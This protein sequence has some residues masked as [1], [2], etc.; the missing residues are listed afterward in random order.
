MK[1]CFSKFLRVLAVEVDFKSLYSVLPEGYF[2]STINRINTQKLTE[3]QLTTIYNDLKAKIKT[4]PPDKRDIFKSLILDLIQ[5]RLGKKERIDI[6]HDWIT[7]FQELKTLPSEDWKAIN[8][9]IKIQ[10]EGLTKG[11]PPSQIKQRSPS[12]EPSASL[13]D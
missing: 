3:E 6:V 11:V 4:L 2:K 10:Q 7:K 13:V 8:R 9:A 5:V 12:Y 1:I